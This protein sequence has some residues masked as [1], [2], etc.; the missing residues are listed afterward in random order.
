MPIPALNH[1][2]IAGVIECAGESLKPLEHLWPVDVSHAQPLG[3]A[4]QFA[5]VPSSDNDAVRHHPYLNRH[6]V[7]KSRVQYPLAA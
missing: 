4:S 6:P 1:R 2:Q 7:S 3:A 5:A